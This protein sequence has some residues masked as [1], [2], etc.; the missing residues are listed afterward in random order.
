MKRR[1]KRFVDFQ[2]YIVIR[3]RHYFQMLL[4]QRGYTGKLKFDHENETLVVQVSLRK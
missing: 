4:S 2:R 3:A 1:A